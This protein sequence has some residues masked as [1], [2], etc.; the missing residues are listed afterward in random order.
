[1][2]EYIVPSI[3]GRA[4]LYGRDAG[5]A[6]SSRI[7]SALTMHICPDMLGKALNEA[8]SRF[9]QIAVGLASNDGRH[10]FMCPD[11]PV[12]VFRASESC[13]IDF[14]DPAL[15]GYLFRVSYEHKS[16]YF[17]YHRAVADECGMM[18]FVKAVILRYLELTGYS[19]RTDGS[20]KLLSSECFKAEWED[21]MLSVDDL[22]ASRPVW[23]MDAKAVVP[24]GQPG[25]EEQVVQLRI[26][27]G[28]LKKGYMDMVN[29]PVT[30]IAPLFSHA[31]HELVSGKM[32]VGEY[33]V[34]SV[35]VNL[36]PYFPSSTLVPYGTSVLLAYN[37]NL[38]DYPYDT[39]LMSQKKLL[40]AQLKNDT[41]AYSAQR[42]IADIEKAYD[43]TASQ[44][45]LDDRFDAMRRA[46]SSR[47]TYDIAKI[48]NV[49]LPD[50]MQ[51]LV[52][53]LY[54]V[55]PAGDRLFS[56]TVGTFRNELVVTV[57]GKK[58]VDAVCTRLVELMQENSIE[59]YISDMYTFIPMSKYGKK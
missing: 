10:M 8:V 11:T 5:V 33:V 20:V 30:Y 16:I 19:V 35:N 7:V 49:I 24:E 15:N 48:G 51:C 18:A 39:V 26:P 47:S 45:E 50:S 23:Y 13:P 27:V 3:C 9:P 25:H 40:E 44:E 4:Y 6:V 41:L 36:R 31:V 57:S 21:S 1:M 34:A 43:D 46:V 17:D 2:K 42:K 22:P 38:A 37:R 12:P 29:I 54:P 32:E 55:V 59:A 56:V 53:E 28:K 58:S 14:S 52:T